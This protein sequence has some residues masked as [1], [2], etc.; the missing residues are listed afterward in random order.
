METKQPVNLQLHCSQS[1]AG[2]TDVYLITATDGHESLPP[3]ES[4]SLADV[5]VEDMIDM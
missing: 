1:Q 3:R 5:A 2:E 4:S